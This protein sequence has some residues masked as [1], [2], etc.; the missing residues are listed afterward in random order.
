MFIPAMT[1]I[2]DP[3]DGH[4][5]VLEVDLGAIVANWRLLSARH[6]SGAVAG[7]APSP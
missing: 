6:P 5:A 2:D 1:A 4:G 3:P 7:V